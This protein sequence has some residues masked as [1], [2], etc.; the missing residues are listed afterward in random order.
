MNTQTLLSADLYTLTPKQRVEALNSLFEDLRFK[1]VIRT[2]KELAEKLHANK[3]SFCS[4][5]RGDETY[6]TTSLLRRAISFYKENVGLSQSINLNNSPNSNIATQQSSI[7][8]NSG[9]PSAPQPGSAKLVPVIPYSLYNGHEGSLMK[10]L[11]NDPNLRRVP[12]V[13]Q[14]P[15]TD[16]YLFAKDNAMHPQIHPTDVLALSRCDDD[17]PIVNGEV[18]VIHAP[19]VG[20]LVR[21]VY[22]MGAEVELR[23]TNERFTAFRIERRQITDFFRVVGVMRTNV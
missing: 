1:G 15:E 7:T 3:S 14:F 22:D 16:A 6:C 11:L 17:A 2:R 18:Y 23:S 19:K 13:A 20:I 12:E 9:I 5:L 4:A 21:Y 10:Q 8:V